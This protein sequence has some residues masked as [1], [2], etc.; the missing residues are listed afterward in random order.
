MRTDQTA[1]AK[2]PSGGDWQSAQPSERAAELVLPGPA[3]WQMQ[4]EAPRLVGEASGGGKAAP[5]QG[6]GGCHCLSLAKG[7]ASGPAGPSCPG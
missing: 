3:Q 5:P 2:P 7:D 6:L 1:T 4:S